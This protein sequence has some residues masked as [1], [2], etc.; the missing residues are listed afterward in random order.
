MKGKTMYRLVFILWLCVGSTCFGQVEIIGKG[1]SKVPRMSKLYK[2]VL[3]IPANTTVT[4]PTTVDNEVIEIAGTAK[5]S[6]TADTTIKTIN[7]QVLPG[8]TL[9]IG[10]ETDPVLRKVN[11]TFKDVPLLTGV[12]GALGPDPEQFGNG[13]MVLG[14]YLSYGRKLD[15]GF[16]TFQPVEAKA[17][18][19]VLT[20]PCNWQIGDNLLFH[21]TRLQYFF[22]NEND[23]PVREETSVTIK[24]INGQTVT[25]SKP[26]DFEH[27][28][29]FGMLPYVANATRNIVI[30][31][32]NPNGTRGHVMFID[33]AHVSTYYT[34]Y[35]GLGRTLPK[36]INNFDGNSMHVG[37]NQIARYALHWHHV[38][39][40]SDWGGYTG[41]AVGNYLNG[42]DIAKWGIVQHGTHDLLVQD[43]VAYNFVGACFVTEDGYEVRGKYLNNLG[44][45]CRGNGLNGKFNLLPIDNFAPG[46][47]GSPFWFHGSQHTIEGNVALC[48]A[49]GYSIPHR[50]QVFNRSVPSV[51]GGENDTPLN[52]T[53]TKF[54]STKNNLA[55]S[56]MKGVEIWNTPED[57][58]MD[59]L[60]VLNAGEKGVFCGNGEAAF[61]TLRNSKLLNDNSDIEPTV[62]LPNIQNEGVH[63]SLGYTSGVILENVE[64]EGFATGMLDAVAWTI[65]KGG[66]IKSRGIDVNWG[67]LL[68]P[69]PF[70]LLIDGTKLEGVKKLIIGHGVSAPGTALTSNKRLL[71]WQGTGKNYYVF[72]VHETPPGATKLEGVTGVVLESDAPPPPPPPPP[73]ENRVPL[74]TAITINPP[75][76]VY[77]S[78]SVNYSASASDLDN[79]ELLW[80]VRYSY[81]GGTPINSASGTGNFASVDFHY[82]AGA[83]VYLW[84][85][86]FSDSKSTGTSSL[87]VNVLVKP[88]DPP[89]PP[90]PTDLEKRVTTL[91]ALVV[92]LKTTLET[93]IAA[94]EVV[95]ETLK[96]TIA[97]MEKRLTSVEAKLKNKG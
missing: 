72:G 77:E 43:N 10:S 63:S 19:I 11:I 90:P 97:A 71:N 49:V 46:S 73:T 86:S 12:D 35:V 26:L 59:D 64:I 3:T 18:E 27:R 51:P 1:G 44:A 13:L 83:R 16:N 21:D 50:Q 41:R 84:E 5:I 47:E 78:T 82:P 89:P 6:R 85:F 66:R 45:Y 70:P 92:T 87:V 95:V 62:F 36:H 48:S 28:V 96:T 91:E 15:R 9:D 14:Q 37:T 94:L 60:T 32:E 17:T 4:L 39:G 22:G 53:L 33:S 67:G 38:H 42:S 52:P 29:V 79:D 24:A 68:H 56:C 23:R 81:G 88:V 2:N 30:E 25:L 7:I 34:S 76:P 8:G 57:W 61:L 69:D 75:P 31:S 40:H 93:R 55:W 80:N 65:A 58:Y 74:V 54:I 20:A